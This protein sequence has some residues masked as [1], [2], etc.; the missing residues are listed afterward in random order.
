MCAIITA[1]PAF[2]NLIIPTYAIKT[3]QSI[4]SVTFS[5][6]G[7]HEAWHLKPFLITES[8]DHPSL[9]FSAFSCG[10]RF[11]QSSERAMAET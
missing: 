6:F 3:V 4:S 8:L 2:N 1:F 9:E 11:L 10:H 5:K 7:E